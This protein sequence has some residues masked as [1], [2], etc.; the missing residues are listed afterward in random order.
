LLVAGLAGSG[1]LVVFAPLVLLAVAPT[2]LLVLALLGGWFPG[3]SAIERWRERRARPRRISH[4]PSVVTAPA[5]GVRRAARLL[6]CFSLANRPPP[7][8][9]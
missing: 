4:A 8:G 9:V 6:I 7:V 2:L 5:A 1:A 3:E